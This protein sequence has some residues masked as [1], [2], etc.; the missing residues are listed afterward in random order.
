V[1]VLKRKKKG[2]EIFE[3]LKCDATMG[4]GFDKTL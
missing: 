4:E 1:K 3:A 2:Q